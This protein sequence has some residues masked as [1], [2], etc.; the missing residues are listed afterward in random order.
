MATIDTSNLTTID[1]NGTEVRTLK[2]GTTTVYNKVYI[3]FDE[4]GGSAVSNKYVYFGGS[5]TY[6]TLPTPTRSGYTFDGWF[7]TSTGSIQIT[8]STVV[9]VTTSISQTLYAQWTSSVQQTATPSIS[10]G[11][12][13]TAWLI[14]VTNNDGSAATI[15]AE[16]NDSTPDINRGVV[17]SGATVQF[18]INEPSFASFTVYA[19][20]QASGEQLSNVASRFFT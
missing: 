3:T 14:G 13:Y 19:T 17:N 7:T 9:T 5:R 8:S 20:A 11:W 18:Q 10:G 16:H 6:G 2:Y 4:Q 15:Y 12:F 1:Y